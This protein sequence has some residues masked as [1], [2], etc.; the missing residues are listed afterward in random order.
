MS[1]SLPD[2]RNGTTTYDYR[3]D[4]PEELNNRNRRVGWIVALVAI[5]LMLLS[6]AYIYWFGGTNKAPMQP[7]HSSIVMQASERTV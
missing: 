5:L 2:H 4:R 1:A 3:V 7:H 6:M